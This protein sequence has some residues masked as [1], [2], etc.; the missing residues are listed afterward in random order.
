MPL[1][2]RPSGPTVKNETG[3]PWLSFSDEASILA[4]TWWSTTSRPSLNSA[5]RTREEM[6]TY[7]VCS[8]PLTSIYLYSRF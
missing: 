7:A 1:N 5:S 4:F 6:S 3:V 2:L 8:A